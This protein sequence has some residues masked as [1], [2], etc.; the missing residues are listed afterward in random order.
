M[1]T[2]RIW[3]V[4]AM[5]RFED[6]QEILHTSNRSSFEMC[7]FD[8]ICK[9]PC[10]VYELSYD[11]VTIGMGGISRE[12]NG[13]QS[14]IWLCFTPEYEKHKLAFLKLSKE[15]LM[16]LVDMYG[17]LTNVVWLKN[18]THVEYLNWLGAKWYP[19]NEDFAVFMLG[20]EKL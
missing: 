20:D 4:S 1:G 3:E 19:I 13:N 17:V 11:G 18:K 9:Y 6:K 8:L 5:L 7:V 16:K 2:K 10:P 12:F 15:L 14:V